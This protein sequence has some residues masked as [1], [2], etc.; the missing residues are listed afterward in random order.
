MPTSP[1]DTVLFRVF[2]ADND[3]S[4]RPVEVHVGIQ[5]RS[6]IDRRRCC[7]IQS[8]FLLLR[9]KREEHQS[10]QRQNAHQCDD[11]NNG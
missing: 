2:R 1:Q 5:C 3:L 7:E 9:C 4:Q 11:D 6:V 8:V 10:Q